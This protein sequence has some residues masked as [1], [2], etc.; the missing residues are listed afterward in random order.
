MDN[1]ALQKEKSLEF[2]Q[3][4]S[5]TKWKKGKQNLL[6]ITHRSSQDRNALNNHDRTSQLNLNQTQ[7]TTASNSTKTQLGQSH[8]LI[9]ED[10][11]GDESTES[12]RTSYLEQMWNAPPHDGIISSNSVCFRD[13]GNY[14]P[15]SLYPKDVSPPYG[16]GTSAS[17]LAAEQMSAIDWV[18]V[19]P[20]EILELTI[21]GGDNSHHSNEMMWSMPQYT[22]STIPILTAPDYCINPLNT[23]PRGQTSV[24]DNPTPR[25]ATPKTITLDSQKEDALFMHYLDDLFYTQNAFYNPADKYKRAW[26]FSVIKQVKPAYYATL[27]LSE[28]DLLISSMPQTQNMDIEAL[29]ER[30]RAKD[31]Y[32]DL[33]AQ[34]LKS[35]LDDAQN[36]QGQSDLARC[37]EGLTSILQVLYWEVCNAYWYYGTAHPC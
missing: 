19:A 4:V 5:H 21:N 6:Y 28:R 26:L 22:T 7:T 16:P 17:E 15:V 37:V 2:K 29:I 10:R 32:Y 8:C 1:G 25:C 27:A 14:A 3:I 12:E 11:T 9:G 20:Q 34:G 30:L 36:L 33:A 23:S 35:Y 18:D 24:S 31:S 13:P